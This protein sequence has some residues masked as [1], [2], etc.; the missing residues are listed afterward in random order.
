MNNII[1]FVKDNEAEMLGG[2]KNKAV[3][4]YWYAQKGLAIINELRYL[5]MGIFGIYYLTKM[6][7]PLLLILM[8]GVSVPILIVIGWV[9]VHHMS[10]VLDFLGVRYTT[11]FGRYGYELQERQ[12]AACEKLVELITSSK[13]IEN[14]EKKGSS[15]ESIKVDRLDAGNPY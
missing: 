7:N 15:K 1:K 5:A 3:R 14:V 13:E 4:W 6:S 12:T 2:A 11:A 9:S 10:V 8:F